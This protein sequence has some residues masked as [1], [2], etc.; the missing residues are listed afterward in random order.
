MDTTLA[1]Y[2][3]DAADAAHTHAM[4]SGLGEPAAWVDRYV[5]VEVRYLPLTRVAHIHDATLG[6]MERHAEVFCSNSAE[7]M[8]PGQS[9]DLGPTTTMLYLPMRDARAIHR[10]FLEGA[11]EL[12][13]RHDQSRVLD[14][15]H[16]IVTIGTVIDVD[17]T[18]GTT[19]DLLAGVT[20]SR[21]RTTDASFR[22]EWA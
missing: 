2:L 19:E 5:Q 4:L 13:L 1:H 17:T 6:T 21:E 18:D 15:E 16:I 22:R 3:A 11:V 7:T 10:M 9:Y 14:I 20:Y 12:M 8:T